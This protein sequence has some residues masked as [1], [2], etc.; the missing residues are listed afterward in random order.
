MCIAEPLTSIRLKFARLG[1][2]RPWKVLYQINHK[3]GDIA[4]VRG[5]E[6]E[7]LDVRIGV[8]YAKEGEKPSSD[9][10]DMVGVQIEIP[11][12]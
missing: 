2:S 8:S 12:K 9:Q 7:V 3:H 4:L 1:K 6:A 5:A 10:H 11:A